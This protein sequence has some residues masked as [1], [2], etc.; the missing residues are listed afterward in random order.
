MD[1]K[2][3]KTLDSSSVLN[4]KSEAESQKIK[5]Q[6]LINSYESEA[7]AIKKKYD[8]VED[9]EFIKYMELI[10]AIKEGDVDTVIIPSS[11]K[12]NLLINAK[13]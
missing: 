6:S 9:K 5:S 2:F 11:E 12:D 13:N 4:S 1:F 7:Q 8:V 3:V 10:N